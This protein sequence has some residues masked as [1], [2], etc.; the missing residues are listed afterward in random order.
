MA[1][2][3]HAGLGYRAVQSTEG[4][5]A[6]SLITTVAPNTYGLGI[7]GRPL[8]GTGN[9]FEVVAHVVSA[10]LVLAVA[11]AAFGLRRRTG[12][13]GQDARHRSVGDLLPLRRGRDLILGWG[14]TAVR[15]VSGHLPV[16]KGN[17]IG[18][19]RAVLGFAFAVLAALGFDWLTGGAPGTPTPRRA[20]AITTSPGARW[21]RPSLGPLVWVDVGVV[22]IALLWRAR[23]VAIFAAY[24]HNLWHASW[25]PMVLVVAA[26]LLVLVGRIRPRQG[27]LAAFIL[28]PALPRRRVWPSQ[29]ISMERQIHREPLSERR[30][31]RNP[32]RL[33]LRRRLGRCSRVA[34]DDTKPALALLNHSVHLLVMRTA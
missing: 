20:G 7:G 32:R 19:I 21:R 31:K 14:P 25:I 4:L 34:H 30:R 27:Q 11:G 2:Y 33:V 10:A 12:R 13:S 29:P 28:I 24:W 17:N 1:W 22:G 9:P 26:L 8:Y 5:A 18:R 16:F 3:D 23:R 15:E 6:Y